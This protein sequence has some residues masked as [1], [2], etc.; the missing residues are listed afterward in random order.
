[1]F[2]ELVGTNPARLPFRCPCRVNPGLRTAPHLRSFVDELRHDAYG[3]FHDTARTNPDS[4]RTRNVLKLLRGGNSFSHKMFK[5]RARLARAANHA[6]KQE[7][8]SNPVLKDQRVVLVA[9]S[10]N[11]SKRRTFRQRFCQ[12]LLPNRGFQSGA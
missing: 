10:N 12:Q 4:D 1:M 3:N 2:P 5:D 8:L 7:W 9:A 11:E 6:Q